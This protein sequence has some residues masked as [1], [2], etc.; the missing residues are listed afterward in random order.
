MLRHWTACGRP[1]V[2][3]GATTWQE[4]VLGP[5]GQDYLRPL[6]AAGVRFA[7]GLPPT[8]GESWRRLPVR[9]C[10]IS[11]GADPAP[12]VVTSLA[13][14]PGELSRLDE[15]IRAPRGAPG[16]S[17]RPAHRA[18]PTLPLDVPRSALHDLRLLW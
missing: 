17:F 4:P 13:R 10:W 8:R 5:V 7:T 3:L 2:L 14:L 15:L 1:L 6:A 18:G 11:P 9:R 12:G 16:C